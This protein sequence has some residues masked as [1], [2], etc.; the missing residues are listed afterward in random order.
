MFLDK[1]GRRFFC[2]NE[3]KTLRYVLTWGRNVCLQECVCVCVCVSVRVRVRE[4]TPPPSLINLLLTS[5]ETAWRLDREPFKIWSCVLQ[6]RTEQLQS[7]IPSS[8]SFCSPRSVALG[9][10]A[11][12]RNKLL[13]PR[14]LRRDSLLVDKWMRGGIYQ[15]SWWSVMFSVPVYSR[16]SA[17]WYNVLVMFSYPEYKRKC[18]TSGMSLLFTTSVMSEICRISF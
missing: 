5:T 3:V 17:W 16:I 6:W 15:E 12:C 11:L 9:G 13:T 14:C 1:R 2:N 4:Q 8:Q 7:I 18:C 10:T